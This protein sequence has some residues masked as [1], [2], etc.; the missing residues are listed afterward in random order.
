M[1]NLPKFLLRSLLF[2]VGLILAVSCQSS[3]PSNDLEPSSNGIQGETPSEVVVD[4]GFSNW[5][6]WYPWQVAQEKGLF[7]ENG[8]SVNLQWFDTY[9]A[10]L[11]AFK[12]GQLDANSQTLS[13]TISS[14]P[15]GF[16][17]VIVLINDISM[18]NDQIIANEDIDVIAD[19]RGKTVAVEGG[20]AQQML[21]LY[22]LKDREISPTTVSTITALKTEAIAAGF[23]AFQFEAAG[24]FPPHTTRALQRK[25][26]KV[27]VS[28]A[29]YPGAISDH[30]VINRD[31]V[32][33]HPEVVQGLV[34]TWFDT[35][36][37]IQE[38]P[39]ESRQIMANRGNISTSEYLKYSAGIKLYN[40]Q[41]NRNA[42]RAQSKSMT[43][44]AHA[45]AL[46]NQFLLDA[47]LIYSPADISQ[48]LD[49]RFVEAYQ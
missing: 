34:N 2:S 26:S 27:L 43:S 28:S 10:S 37:F 15:L 44:L 18:G 38:N 5:L 35:L 7:E 42:F 8:V 3:S 1:F 41:D 23:V 40:Y 24:L 14:I 49:N 31:L 16:D 32:V 17:P 39:N 9:S 6:G 12:S 22:A 4:L 25:G 13:D 46:T 21:L 11:K 20:S 47:K 36:R 45:A 30:L 29:D 19:L 33:N 48:L